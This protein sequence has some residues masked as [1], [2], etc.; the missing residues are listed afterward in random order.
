M[1][2]LQLFFSFSNRTKTLFTWWRLGPCLLV[3]FF[4]FAYGEIRLGSTATHRMSVGQPNH[5]A[6]AEASNSTDDAGEAVDFTLCSSSDPIGVAVDAIEKKLQRGLSAEQTAAT[7]LSAA[8]QVIT[9]LA[10]SDWLGPLAPLALSP[11]FG[12]TCLSGLAIWSPDW[13]PVGGLLAQSTPLKNQ[14]LFWV[15]AVLTLVTSL[16]RFSKISKP[17]A[18]AIDQIEAYAGIITLLVI[19][20]LVTSPGGSSNAEGDLVFQAGIFSLTL[21][22]ILYIV[23]AVN[24]LVINSVKLFFEFMIWITPLPFLDACF[25]IANKSAC[26]FLIAVYSYSP[27]FATV[28][29]AILFVVCLVVFRWAHRRMRFCRHLVF[30]AIWPAFSRNYGVPKEDKLTVFATTDWCGIPSRT[31]LTLC[32]QQ[33]R[34]VLRQKKFFQSPIDHPLPA[35]TLFKITPGWMFNELEILTQEPTRMV[36]SRRYQRCLD[37]LACR[38]GA[39]ILTTQTPATSTANVGFS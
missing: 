36:F 14:T 15:F 29:N 6:S 34:W 11:F 35:G 30:D 39:E 33:D 38:I 7:D 32:R 22:A 31:E 19:R 21:D 23:M 13:M 9:A 12:I 18:V 3:M 2:P 27:W 5:P 1:K 4:L 25:E 24:V 17:I 8:N 26:A 16:P 37:V 20:Y 28:F 10:P